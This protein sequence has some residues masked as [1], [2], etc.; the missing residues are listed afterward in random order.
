MMSEKIDI[1]FEDVFQMIQKEEL[2]VRYL[3]DENGEG[4]IRI[5]F[6]EDGVLDVIENSNLSDI[7]EKIFIVA[8]NAGMIIPSEF[9][10]TI[11]EFVKS[12]DFSSDLLKENGII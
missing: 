7:L 3:E 9:Y 6:N 4:Q 5:G 11:E 2:A 10:R 8:S 1:S 12:D